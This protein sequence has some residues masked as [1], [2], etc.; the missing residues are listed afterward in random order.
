MIL[1]EKVL[2]TNG[3]N[4]ISNIKEVDRYYKNHDEHE[5][6]NKIRNIYN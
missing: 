6:Y 2:D 5:K 4:I 3:N 1:I